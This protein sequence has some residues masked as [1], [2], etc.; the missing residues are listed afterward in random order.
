M[1][2]INHIVI[3]VVALFSAC[4][5]DLNK[6]SSCAEAFRGRIVST[7]NPCA[8]VAIQ[9]LSGHVPLGIADAEW[10]DTF[11]PSGQISPYVFTN[12]FKVYPCDIEND[13]N[14]LLAF[15]ESSG[16]FINKSDFYFYVT[17]NSLLSDN[18]DGCTICKRLVSLPKKRN[19]IALSNGCNDLI[20]IE[21]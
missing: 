10:N 11:Q 8:G 2:K 15:N 14:D 12:V 3:V 20:V 1:R 9:I 17:S 16:E 13:L 4:E 6:S 7:T 5:S 21:D 18:N 19:K